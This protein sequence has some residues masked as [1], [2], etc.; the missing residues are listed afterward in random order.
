MEDVGGFAVEV[1]CIAEEVREAVNDK[2]SIAAFSL[3]SGN[4]GDAIFSCVKDICGEASEEEKPPKHAHAFGNVQRLYD[5]I[6]DERRAAMTAFGD[7]VM[8]GAYSHAR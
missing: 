6:R 5:Q 3:G 7:E 4:A 8:A 2:P 1:E